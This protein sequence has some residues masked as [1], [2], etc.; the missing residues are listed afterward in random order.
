MKLTDFHDSVSINSRTLLFH[1][2]N[3]GPFGTNLSMMDT[4][5]PE[6]L[7]T[8]SRCVNLMLSPLLTG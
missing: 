3:V 6:V 8:H 7:N 4:L 2:R 1:Y 5:A